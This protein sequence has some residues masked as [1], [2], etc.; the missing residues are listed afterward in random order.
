MKT[1]FAKEKKLNEALDK[2]NNFNFLD[3]SASEE[4][5]KLN[6]QKKSIRN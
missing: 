1:F 6:N 4:L 5:K 3:S 2:L